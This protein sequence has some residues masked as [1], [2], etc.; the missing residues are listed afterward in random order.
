MGT[1]HWQMVNENINVVSNTPLDLWLAACNYFKWCDDNPIKTKRAV[2]VGKEA[3]KEVETTKQ[4]PYSIKALCL[5]CN[6]TEE[7]LRDIR[8][9]NNNES[10]YY[11]VV[12]KI[13]YIIYTQNAEL[14]MIGEYN[15]IFVG[16]MLNIDS[17]EAPQANIK[18]EIVQGLPQLS[19]SESE[20]LEK[21]DLE[22][23]I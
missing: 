15:S 21:L 22:N 17:Q 1:E 14:A 19:K 8:R 12:S 6:V 18:V 11:N 9:L 10:E 13:L 23:G 2:G 4:R 3:G 16:K 7:Y 5:H 20:I